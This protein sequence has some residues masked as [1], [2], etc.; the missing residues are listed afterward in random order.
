MKNTSNFSLNVIQLGIL[1]DLCLVFVI[2]EKLI[3]ICSTSIKY[4]KINN[5]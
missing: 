3:S 2:L 5:S 4:V 1:L